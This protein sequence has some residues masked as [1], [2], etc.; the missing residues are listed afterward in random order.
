MSCNKR[1]NEGSQQKQCGFK[2]PGDAATSARNPRTGTERTKASQFRRTHFQPVK[3]NQPPLTSNPTSN[4][5]LYPTTEHQ[6]CKLRTDSCNGTRRTSQLARSQPNRPE[7]AATLDRTL[8]E[9]RSGRR[10]EKLIAS[11]Q[12]FLNGQVARLDKAL[13]ECQAV[14]T[15]TES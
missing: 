5:D 2:N 3:S 8:A 15:T 9:I 11:I 12:G 7:S 13:D 14:A 1:L 6:T 4:S 10:L